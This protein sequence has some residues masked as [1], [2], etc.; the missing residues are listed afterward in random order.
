M[1]ASPFQLQDHALHGVTVGG[2]PILSTYLISSLATHH[3]RYLAI[4]HSNILN[5]YQL[6]HISLI[7]STITSYTGCSKML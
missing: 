5:F 6:K 1:H 3:I 4:T 2:F 7:G